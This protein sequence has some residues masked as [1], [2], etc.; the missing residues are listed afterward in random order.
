MNDEG[1]N[2]RRAERSEVYIAAE[3]QVLREGDEPRDPA[4]AAVRSAV[5]RDVSAS[6]LLLLTRTTIDVGE[7]V[8]VRVHVPGESIGQRVLF[9]RVVR[10]EPLDESEQGLWRVKVGVELEQASPELGALFAQLAAKQAAL[11]KRKP[12]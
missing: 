1:S 11:F 7:R 4:N 5:T 9:G 10:H 2:R 6:G 12:G 8:R 3:I